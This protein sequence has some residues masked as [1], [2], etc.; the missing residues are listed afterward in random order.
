MVQIRHMA[1]MPIL[2]A[3]VLGSIGMVTSHVSATGGP[4]QPTIKQ[5]MFQDGGGY[6]TCAANTYIYSPKGCY[7]DGHQAARFLSDCIASLHVPEYCQGWQ[8]AQNNIDNSA[9]YAVEQPAR[10]SESGC[11]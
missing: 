2:G 8:D 3:I 11:S 1:I 4:Q 9:N 6:E 7:V 5:A 10:C